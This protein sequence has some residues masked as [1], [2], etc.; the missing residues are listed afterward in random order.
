MSENTTVVHLVRHGEVE[1]PQRVLYGRLHGFHL[2]AEGRVMAKAATDSLA[3]RDVTVL[4]S[5]PLERA[6]ETAEPLAAQFGLE[7]EV[8]ERLA[9]P[10]NHFE[11]MMFGG[12]DGPV[13]RPKDWEYLRNPIRPSWAGPHRK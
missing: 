10:W 3:G 11:G 8:D 9:E 12:G 4:R 1:N 5:S 6:L 2:S 7:A 13:R